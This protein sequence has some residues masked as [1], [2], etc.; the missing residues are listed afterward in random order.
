MT[1]IRL[2]K[3]DK[4]VKEAQHYASLS[5]I[6]RAITVVL[7]SELTNKTATQQEIAS[8]L[9]ACMQDIGLIEIVKK[10]LDRF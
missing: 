9:I 10:D 6:C 1:P 2:S 8:V 3:M 7:D 5:A 4:L